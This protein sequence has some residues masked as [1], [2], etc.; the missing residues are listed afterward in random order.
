A[1]RDGTGAEART[2]NREASGVEIDAIAEGGG[3]DRACYV[4]PGRLETR[5]ECRGGAGVERERS[6]R[7]V[8]GERGDGGGGVVRGGGEEEGAVDGT[9]GVAELRVGG[10]GE[11]EL[12]A[13]GGRDGETEVRSGGADADGSAGVEDAGVLEGEVGSVPLGH[14]VAGEAVDG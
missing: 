7:A 1:E 13:G 3:R 9:E 14:E 4:E 5:R 11:D 10:I 12:G 2:I 8:D 6:R